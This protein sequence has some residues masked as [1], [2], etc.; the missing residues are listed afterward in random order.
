MLVYP[1]GKNSGRRF[2]VLS[3]G[4]GSASG[5]G[6][7]GAAVLHGVEAAAKEIQ[8]ATKVLLLKWFNV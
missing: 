5:E 7:E 2:I 6:G 4:N 3:A 8:Q 1:T